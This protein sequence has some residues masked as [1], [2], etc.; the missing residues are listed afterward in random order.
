MQEK[1]GKKLQ[2]YMAEFFEL[3]RDIVLDLSRLTLIGDRQLHLENHKGIVEYGS[4]GIKV[5]TSSG[6]LFIRGQGLVLR[7]LY[8]AELCVEGE[9][10]ALEL[11]R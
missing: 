2:G 3:P 9:I 10:Q 5:M 1:M 6:L 11:S 4:E 7:H 8:A